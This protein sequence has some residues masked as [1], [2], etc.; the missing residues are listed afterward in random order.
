MVRALGPYEEFIDIRDEAMYSIWKSRR[1]L[2]CL[3]CGQ[4]LGIYHQG[5]SKERFLRHP[6]SSGVVPTGWR[7]VESEEHAAVKYW[8][9]DHLRSIGLTDAEVEQRAGEQFPDVSGTRSGRTFAVE[10]QFSPLDLATAA[11]RT[12]GLRAAGC[13]QV[14]WIARHCD[15]IERLPAAGL[16]DFTP[17]DEGTYHLHTGHL[18][19][20]TARSGHRALAVQKTSLSRFLTRWVDQELVWA[21]TTTTTAGWATVTDWEHH[22]RDQAAQIAD[23]QQ[24]LRRSTTQTADACRRRDELTTQLT[25]AA[26]ELRAARDELDT[27]RIRHTQTRDNLNADIA[28]LRTQQAQ[29]EET[30]RRQLTDQATASR[31][32]KTAL[33]SELEATRRRAATWTRVALVS[34]LLALLLLAVLWL[35]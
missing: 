1:G 25:D 21:Y 15:W 33:T 29:R 16:A 24:R 8:I 10:V 9:R 32:E 3:Y 20:R 22:T 17:S 14:L 31:Q 23:L 5:R 2:R 4:G 27:E 7:S 30:Q 13:N 11:A 34:G 18:A 6:D 19:L 28:A 12:A 35:I 26:E